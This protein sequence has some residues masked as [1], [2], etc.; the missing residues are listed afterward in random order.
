VIVQYLFSVN[1]LINPR[2]ACFFEYP[3]SR[4]RTLILKNRTVRESE[5]VVVAGVDWSGGSTKC[6]APTYVITHVSTFNICLAS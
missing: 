2:G 4:S 1:P 3:T 5:G 6:C